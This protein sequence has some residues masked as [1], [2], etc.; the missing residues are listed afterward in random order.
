LDFAR[1][2]CGVVGSD[3]AAREARPTIAQMMNLENI[4]VEKTMSVRDEKNA[5]E[6]GFALWP[7]RLRGSDGSLSL[8]KAKVNGELNCRG[9]IKSRRSDQSGFH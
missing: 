2:R 3:A 1:R 5:H 6:S 8:H 9:E 4:V 7:L